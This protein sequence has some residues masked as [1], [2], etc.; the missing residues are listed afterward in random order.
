MDEI[1]K[2]LERKFNVKILIASE[3]L[4]NDR[5]FAHFGYNEN[6]EQI[7]TLLSHKRFWKYEKKNGT[8]E[9]RKKY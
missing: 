5:Y 8:I 3:S 6:L 9:I 4:K 7:L 1:A 2:I